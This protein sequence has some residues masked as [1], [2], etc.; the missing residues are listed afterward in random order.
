M[1][2]KKIKTSQS[3]FHT[4]F[5]HYF[6]HVSYQYEKCLLSSFFLWDLCG[7]IIIS[8]PQKKGHPVD[9]SEILH[10]LG[11][12]KNPVNN[13]INYLSLNRWLAGFLPSPVSPV[14]QFSEAKD[15]GS[16]KSKGARGGGEWGFVHHGNLPFPSVFKWRPSLREY[17]KGSYGG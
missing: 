5:F 10:Q 15:C 11:C 8:F 9:G 6:F 4:L 1:P 16:S 7:L 3:T 14:A 12:K 17:L 2:H 13:G